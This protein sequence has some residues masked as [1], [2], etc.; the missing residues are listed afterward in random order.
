MATVEQLAAFVGGRVEGDGSVEITGVASVEDAE[1]G[2]IVLAENAKYF[3]AAAESR[4][5]AVVAAIASPPGKEKEAAASFLSR[6]G[7]AVIWAE[8]AR[9]AF[10]R[11]IEYFAPPRPRR[12]GIDP[13]CRIGERFSCGRDVYI[14]YGCFVGDDVALGDEVSLAPCVFIGDG[15][16]IGSG[17][18]IHAGAV[19]HW[20][21]EIGERVVIHSGAVIGADGF[22]YVRVGGT[23]RK[24]PQIG[25]VVIEDEVEIG[26]NSTVDRAKT[27]VT[28]IGRGTKI[29]NLV[30]VAHNVSIG[31]NCLIV[32]QAGIAGSATIG[33]GVVI[34]GQVGIKDHIHIGDGAVIAAQAGVIGDVPAGSVLCGFPARERRRFWRMEAS[35]ERLPE[36]LKRVSVLE[37]KLE[38]ENV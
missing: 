29:D 3:Q 19:V 14:G 5:S 12:I 8:D 32:A 6:E 13:N 35:L 22:G 1:S 7:K 24:I 2:D 33:D 28:R 10:A 11:I 20:G 15:V 34:A 16:R 31:Q 9:A 38:E 26:A 25:R 27:G 17:S 18:V 4:A 30:M 36:L 23:I 21:T 37:K